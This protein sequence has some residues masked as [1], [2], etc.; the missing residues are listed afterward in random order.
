[1]LTFSNLFSEIKS[2]ICPPTIPL[3]PIDLDNSKITF[4][5]T[6]KITDLNNEET[7]IY[8]IVG[9]DESD[10]EKMNKDSKSKLNAIYKAKSKL[11]RDLLEK[12]GLD[13]PNKGAN[14]ETKSPQ[15]QKYFSKFSKFGANLSTTS[16]HH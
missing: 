8:T 2:Y 11:K 12:I 9:A 13:D 3:K 15:S 4:G 5:A 1:M 7:H 10:I 14:E 16:L 6:V